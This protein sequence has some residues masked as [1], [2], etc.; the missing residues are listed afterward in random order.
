[1]VVSAE[2]PVHVGGFDFDVGEARG[3]CVGDADGRG[4]RSA[5][6]FSRSL[7]VCTLRS[8]VRENEGA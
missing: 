5:Q 1:M 7:I 4:A 6:G 2:C 3:E 8:V